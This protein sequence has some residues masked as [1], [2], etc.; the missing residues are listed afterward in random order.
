MFRAAILGF[1]LR[2]LRVHVQRRK[3]APAPLCSVLLC[4]RQ[5]GTPAVHLAQATDPDHVVSMVTAISSYYG[6]HVSLAY[7]GGIMSPA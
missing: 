6:P 4:S 2:H 1:V 7:H 3:L 5:R